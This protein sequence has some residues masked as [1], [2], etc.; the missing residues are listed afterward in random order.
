MKIRRNSNLLQTQYFPFKGRLV[1]R[2]ILVAF[3]VFAFLLSPVQA[4]GD[5]SV[6]N[7]WA[8]ATPPGAVNAAIYF[9]LNNT[10]QSDDQLLSA[11]SELADHAGL[12]THIHKDGMMQMTPVDMIGIPAGGEAL[13]KPHGDHVMLTGIRKPLKEGDRVDLDLVFKQGGKMSLKIPVHK[14]APDG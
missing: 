2:F 9:K 8:R 6:E 4:G 11:S 1:E 5:I 10:G 13:L 12:H 14:N 3:V 7:A